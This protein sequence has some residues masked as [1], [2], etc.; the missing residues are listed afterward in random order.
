MA[1]TEF[2]CTNR[3]P[4]VLTLYTQED[5]PDITIETRE[6]GDTYILSAEWDCPLEKLASYTANVFWIDWTVESPREYQLTKLP[7]HNDGSNMYIAQVGCRKYAVRLSNCSKYVEGE[8]R[9]HTSVL[10]KMHVFWGIA[11]KD[12]FYDPSEDA[13][14]KK[15]RKKAEKRYPG[16]DIP[17]MEIP[18]FE[19]E[20]IKRDHD[21]Q[22]VAVAGI[23]TSFIPPLHPVHIRALVNTF[24]DP[25][26]RES[27][28]NDP[29]L[30]N[31][32]F[33]VRLGEMSP[34]DEAKSTRLLSRPVYFDQILREARDFLPRWAVQM[35]MALAILH[36]ACRLDATGVKF[37]LGLDPKRV[38]IWMTNFGDCKPLQPNRDETFEMAQAI[39]NNP[40]WPRA[41][42]RKYRQIDE[43]KYEDEMM[44][45]NMLK[46]TRAI[47]SAG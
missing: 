46:T 24:L 43:E 20:I 4:H 45:E 11:T 1:K 39:H 27:V 41:P 10:W 22:D 32:R 38:K 17:K 23:V 44:E 34:P 30:S 21:R 16:Y 40:A 28:L 6:K 15:K 3:L 42:D 33:Q 18:S 37:Y 26:I 13:A 8:L 29:N 5:S 31:V 35:G 7:S 36:W 25:S 19:S 9:N 47:L 12:F 14:S 2:T